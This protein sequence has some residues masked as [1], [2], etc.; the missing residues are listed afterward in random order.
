MESNSTT[1]SRL[2]TATHSQN[3]SANNWKITN[4]HDWFLP[5]ANEMDYQRNLCSVEDIQWECFDQLF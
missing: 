4:E 3:Y 1:G 5:L 2:S